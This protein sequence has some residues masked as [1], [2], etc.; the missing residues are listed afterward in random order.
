MTSS[1]GHFASDRCIVPEAAVMIVS[2]RHSSGYRVAWPPVAGVPV[3]V[4]VAPSEL[5]QASRCP[6]RCCQQACIRRSAQPCPE[7]IARRI[8]GFIVLFYSPAQW[9]MPGSESREKMW[10]R[11][12][13][14][15]S[16]Q[17]I[18]G[19]VQLPDFRKG[20]VASVA[21]KPVPDDKGGRDLEAGVLNGDRG[22]P[23]AGF[24]D[25]RA[26]PE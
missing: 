26:A 9:H 14:R 25:Q 5:G 6:C 18:G 8:P 13:D 19:C 23:A 12:T 24:V 7:R 10:G 2:S 15:M 22:G 16:G 20:A 1:A 11:G 4:C 17:G 3:L 21:V